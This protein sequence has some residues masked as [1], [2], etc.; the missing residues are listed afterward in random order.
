LRPVVR[1]DSISVGRARFRREHLY[2]IRLCDRPAMA[3]Q[4][5][6]SFSRIVKCNSE[7]AAIGRALIRQLRNWRQPLAAS[8]SVLPR[9]LPASPTV[10]RVA[11]LRKTCRMDVNDD[12]QQGDA[13]RGIKCRI[14]ESP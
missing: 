14:A 1:I 5:L 3:S 11:I 9:L 4:R 10:G 12:S 7:T 2:A 13:R 8:R 6:C